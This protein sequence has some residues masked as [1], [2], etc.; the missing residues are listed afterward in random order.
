MHTH[1]E[2][3]KNLKQQQKQTNYVEYGWVWVRIAYIASSQSEINMF[4]SVYVCA[5]HKSDSM[6]VA[7]S[8]VCKTKYT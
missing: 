5:V 7:R 2:R 1:D 3:T 8:C 4:V 6:L